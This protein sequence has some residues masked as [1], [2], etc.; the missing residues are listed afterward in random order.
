MIVIKI[1]GSIVEG[2]HPSILDD[3]SDLVKKEKIVIVHGGGKDV[4][5]IANSM[6]KEQNF[7]MSP[8]GKRSRYTDKETQ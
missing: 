5:N 6:G 1:G 4:T 8:E 7:I 3:F 2:L